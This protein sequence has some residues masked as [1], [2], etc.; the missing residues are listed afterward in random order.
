M[1][2]AKPASSKPSFSQSYGTTH[3]YQ[4]MS[5]MSFAD[6]HR[7]QGARIKLIR[8]EFYGRRCRSVPFPVR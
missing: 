7:A 2:Y 4:A 1:D 5:Y 8:S 6:T 3:A